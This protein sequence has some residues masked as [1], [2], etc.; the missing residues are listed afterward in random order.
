MVNQRRLI[1]HVDMDAFFAS[2]EQRDR[3]DLRGRPVIVGGDGARG[4]VAAASYEARRYGV[5][6]AMPA[7]RARRLCPHAVFVRAR[8]AHYREVSEAIFEVFAAHAERVEGLSL[9][10]AYLDLGPFDPAILPAAIGRRLKQ[11]VF[12]ATGLT[13]S[14]G[15]AGTKLIA[16]LAS[17]YDKPDGLTWVP[18]ETVQRFLDPLPIRRLPGIGPSTAGRLHDA[19]IFT[20]GQLRQGPESLLS[21]ALG[22]QA[23]TFRQ[24]A[25]GI[26]PRP[27]DDRRVRRSI[28][29]ESTFSEDLHELAAIE[30][31][32]RTQAA[33][34]ARRL[35]E[36]SLYAR[37]V[38]LKLRS[39][40]F[41]TLTRSQSLDGYTRN[42]ETVA[43]AACALARAWA[44]YQ[45]RIG[46][47][48]IGTGVSGLEGQPD[49][50]QIL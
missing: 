34:C 28:S 13:A 11:A 48:L 21:Q 12:D 44:G 14:V 30:E 40:G 18:D 17:D 43:E 39:G 7:A 15:L 42:A 22:R 2:V 16:K 10:E 8:H 36:R 47:R 19:G 24:R 6:S 35:R 46:V 29:Q 45:S 5:R 20:V 26:D 1:A 41:S 3:P 33:A 49:P 25:A 32:I 37:T 9:D 23:G 38:H 27:V 4:V 50:G 31:V